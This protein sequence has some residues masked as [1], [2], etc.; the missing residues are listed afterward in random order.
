MHDN[1]RRTRMHSKGNMKLQTGISLRDD[2]YND[3]CRG[4]NRKHGIDWCGKYRENTHYVIIRCIEDHPFCSRDNPVVK[5][6]ILDIV[7]KDLKMIPIS[8]LL[9]ELS[10]RENTE[11][12]KQSKPLSEITEADAI[13]VVIENALR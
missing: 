8:E 2:R 5:E 1:L 3:R 13:L 11:V 7:R 6:H 9:L 12:V 4:C 10:S